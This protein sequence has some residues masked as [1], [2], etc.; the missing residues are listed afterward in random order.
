MNP[1]AATLFAPD[2]FSIIFSDPAL[3][4]Q[5]LSIL[6]KTILNPFDGGFSVPINGHEYKLFLDAP[7]PTT[8]LL[9][10]ASTSEVPTVNAGNRPVMIVRIDGNDRPPTVDGNLALFPMVR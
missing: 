9:M 2:K 6:R 5:F 10:L 4:S 7:D 8:L 1:K 3:K